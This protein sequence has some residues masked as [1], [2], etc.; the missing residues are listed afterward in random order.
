MTPGAGTDGDGGRGKNPAESA[1]LK[2]RPLLPL[3]GDRKLAREVAELAGRHYPPGWLRRSN[4]R[5]E[6]RVTSAFAIEGAASAV[7]F[8]VALLIW[9]NGIVLSVVTAALASALLVWWLRK[10]GV[11]WYRRWWGHGL[12]CL[13]ELAGEEREANI[14]HELG[15]RM[16]DVVPGLVERER[17]F[18]EGKTSRRVRRYPPAIAA[19][20]RL[21]RGLGEAVRLSLKHEAAR[22]HGF[23]HPYAAFDPLDGRTFEVFAMGYQG[24]LYG[25]DDPRTGAFDP[26]MKPHADHGEFVERVP[27]EL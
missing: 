19:G 20:G 18:L 27:R 8:F 5:S 13:G 16:Q 9:G 7:L 22:Y 1:P 21:L 17:T 3:P 2:V 11:G 4:E 15:H 23:Y 12:I 26:K 6:M 24:L 14:V 10:G 25:A